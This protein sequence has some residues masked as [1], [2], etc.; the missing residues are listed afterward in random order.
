MSIGIMI[1]IDEA[2][3]YLENLQPVDKTDT[4][5]RIANR[6]RYVMAKDVGVK[7]KFH[8]GHYGHKFDHWTCGNC[9]ATTKDGVGDTFCRNCGYRILW[10][11]TRC[12]TG[13][14]ETDVD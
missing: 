2:V 8:K 10:D 9:G 6:L 11:S 4:F 5:Q 13:V 12:L 1:G 3:T 7:P 14:N